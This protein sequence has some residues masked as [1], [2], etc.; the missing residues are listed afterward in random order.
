[1]QAIFIYLQT[2]DDLKIT[3]E[4]KTYHILFFGWITCFLSGCNRTQSVSGTY[5]AN[6]KHGSDT[7]FLY[8][9]N[10]FR[11]HYVS[12]TDSSYTNEG[13]WHYTDDGIVELDDFV[14]YL[15]GYGTR[16]KS[17]GVWPARFDNF[18]TKPF[19]IIDSDLGLKYIKQN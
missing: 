16:N 17:K 9:N 7:V 18:L 5:V 15:P 4:M 12:L 1:M 6:H 19:L 8:G 10:M 2:S 3:D 14:F 13:T 11:Q